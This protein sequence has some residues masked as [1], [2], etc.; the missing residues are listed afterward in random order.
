MITM[1]VLQTKTGD[2]ELEVSGENMKV[3]FD[4][5]TGR[6]TS[7]NYK[8]KELFLKGPEPDFWRPP[9]DNDYGYN[10]DKLLGVWKKAGERTVVTK[11]NIS[12]PDLG[13]VV[14]TFNYDIPDDKWQ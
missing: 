2:K 12:Q 5:A 10:M 14:V 13:K 1:A 4:L 11:A 3:I 7:Y 6:L 9:T 8:G